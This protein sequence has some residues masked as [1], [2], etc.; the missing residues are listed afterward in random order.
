MVN[1][2]TLLRITRFSV[3]FWSVA[4]FA[5]ENYSI[6]FHKEKEE[7]SRLATEC[8]LDDSSPIASVETAS[9]N[10]YLLALGAASVAE[11][12]SSSLS[13]AKTVAHAKALRAIS[14]FMRI[15]VQTEDELKQITTVRAVDGAGREKATERKKTE[16]IQIRSRAFVSQSYIL[17]SRYSSE[18]KTYIVVLAVLLR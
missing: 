7:I 6:I 17:S 2:F 12:T 4:I 10:T 18:T 5:A 3:L 16:S 9:N 8:G 11:E 13:A 15:E 14:Q 1:Y